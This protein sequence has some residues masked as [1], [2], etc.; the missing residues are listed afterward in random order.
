[1]SSC[2]VEYTWIQERLRS[3][4]AK[5]LRSTIAKFHV[6]RKMRR[7]AAEVFVYVHFL[8]YYSPFF[9]YTMG[10]KEK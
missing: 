10:A 9:G 1:M 5:S 2:I 6:A 4:I 7:S 8:V 3:I